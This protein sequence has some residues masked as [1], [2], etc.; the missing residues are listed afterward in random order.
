MSRVFFL[1]S[2]LCMLVG[3][4]LLGTVTGATC[5]ETPLG[6]KILILNSYHSG[7]KGSD[8]AVEGF[9]A[10]LLKALP[11]TEIQVEYLDSKNNSGKEFDA[12]VID[13]LRFKYQK[14]HFDLIF[15]TDDYAFNIIERHREDLFGATPVVFCGTNSFDRSRLSG[16]HGIIGIDERPSFKATLD[17]IFD[18]HP[19]T[20]EIVVIRDDSVTGQLNDME[21]RKAAEQLQDKATF[22]DWAG[23][24]LDQFISRVKQ[25]HPGSVILYFASFVQDENGDRVSS[26]EAL[27]R[28]STVSPVPVYGGWEFNLGEGIVGGRLL[29]LHEHGAAAAALAVRVLK[30]ESIDALPP[31][32]PSPNK[33]MFDYNELRRFGIAQGK[34]PTDSIIVNQP[35]GYLY[36][37]RVEIL[38]TIS[39]LLLLALTMSFTKLIN[40]RKNLQIHRDAL[41]QR[42]EELEQALSKVKVLEG[43]IPVC[44]YCKKVRKDEK[45]WQ[46][47]ESYISQHTEAQFS[48]GICPTCFDDNFSGKKPKQL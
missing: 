33:D 37:H 47:M 27:R 26:N 3:V 23:L 39:V 21:F 43:I 6:K 11:D 20:K 9:R 48:H 30:G 19:A 13:L 4:C 45:S 34:L 7:Y 28:I 25:L 2:L 18:L 36:S 29:N 22:S 40:S 17:L 24:R 14:R 1:S 46:Q 15:S 8:D 38:S 10:T 32:T 5:A 42:N 31:V 12:K 35:P 44:M 16:R 41:V